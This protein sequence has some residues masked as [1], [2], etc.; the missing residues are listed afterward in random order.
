VDLGIFR[1]PSIAYCIILQQHTVA[2]PSKIDE[3]D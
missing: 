2:F 3:S 1:F